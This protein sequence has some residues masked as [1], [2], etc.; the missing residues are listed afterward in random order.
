MQREEEIDARLAAH[1][2]AVARVAQAVRIRGQY[3]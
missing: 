3:P 2:I 1:A